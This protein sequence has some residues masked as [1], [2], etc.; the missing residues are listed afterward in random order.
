[1]KRILWSSFVVVG[2]LV[3]ASCARTTVT[4]HATLPPSDVL[5]ADRL[6][7]TL[8]VVET[9]LPSV[10]GADDDGRAEEAV[11]TAR[12]TLS[13]LTARPG[14]ASAE[15][16]LLRRATA[17]G[18][19]SV[20]VIRVED[21]RRTGELHIGLAVPPVSWETRTVVSVRLRALNVLDGRVIADLRRDRVRG[22]LYTHRTIEDL[23][24]ELAETLRSLVAAPAVPG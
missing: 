7:S 18:L 8:L 10:E 24:G 17:A 21:Y 22:G 11:R 6:G 20:L 4:D 2:L 16:E 5:A 23:P 14:A 9:A 19:D 1:M 12:Q 13:F 3:T 15:T